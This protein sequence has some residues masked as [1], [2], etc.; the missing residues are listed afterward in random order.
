MKKIHVAFLLFAVF[1]AGIGATALIVDQ[2]GFHVYPAT[3]EAPSS[4]EGAVA[5][6]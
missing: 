2:I 4:A 5:S 1:A 6:R 3:Y